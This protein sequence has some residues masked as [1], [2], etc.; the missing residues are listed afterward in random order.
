MAY[1][2]KQIYF[3]F[4][5]LNYADFYSN[6]HLDSLLEFIGFVGLIIT[7]SLDVALILMCG[8][9]RSRGVLWL[10]DLALLFSLAHASSNHM[11]TCRTNC[12]VTFPVLSDF[13]GDCVRRSIKAAGHRNSF[14]SKKAM[15]E[16]A[17]SKGNFTFCKSS[18]VILKAVGYV[19][20]G[21]CKVYQLFR[22]DFGLRNLEAMIIVGVIVV[23]YVSPESIL[24][25]LESPKERNNVQK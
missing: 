5:G 2:E 11:A 16:N 10:D 15:S 1:D 4:F 19:Y 20:H 24:S 3:W 14:T 9:L 12:V 25:A 17:C 23:R 6:L 22:T 21:V 18:K 8:R 13:F 7:I